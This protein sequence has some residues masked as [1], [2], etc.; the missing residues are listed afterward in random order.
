V[1]IKPAIGNLKEEYIRKLTALD[2]L[3]KSTRRMLG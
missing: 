3:G 1:E 2:L